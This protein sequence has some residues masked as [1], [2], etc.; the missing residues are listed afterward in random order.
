[1]GASRFQRFVLPAFAFKAVVIGGGYATGRELAEYFLP[2]GP[3]GGLM[4]MALAA[5]FW[6]VVCAVT[7]MVAQAT[8]SLDYRSF[9]ANL[10]GRAGIVFELAYYLFVLVAL[11]VFGAASGEIG[12]ALLGLP[13]VAGTLVL[14][15][16]IAGV[17]AFGNDAVE[18]LF[19]YAT[20][21]LYGTYALFLVL[22]LAHFR[23]GIG[24][25]FA[26]AAPPG[27]AWVAGGVTYASYNIIG[28]AVILPVCRHLTSQRDALLAGLLC[29]PLAMLPAILF[30]LCMLA[31]YPAIGAASLPSDFLL[32]RL[33]LPAFRVMFQLMIFAALLESG[34][35]MVHAV[36]ERLARSWNGWRGNAMP[37]AARLGIALVLLVFA[38]EIAGR[39]GLVMLIARGY[40]ALA[41][42]ILGVYVLPLMTVGIWRL[43]CADMAGVAV[44]A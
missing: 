17:V 39:F 42:I 30:F 40:R 14:S 32:Q 3:L 35:G 25:A 19:K 16:S 26:P 9:F 7:F 23:G 28:A 31:F 5:V 13:L 44:S 11:S 18:A 21:L 10:L 34:T 4:G 1:V 33:D 38:T 8:R 29:G 43:R 37:A 15:A 36:N 41:W 12:R 27:G 6:S 2:A 22:C 20:I 24:A